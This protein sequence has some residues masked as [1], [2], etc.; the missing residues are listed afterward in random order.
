MRRKNFL[1]TFLVAVIISVPCFSYAGE[2]SPESESDFEKTEYA[3]SDINSLLDDAVYVEGLEEGEDYAENQ[4]FCEASDIDEALRIAEDYGAELVSFEEGIAVLST[5]RDVADI[6]LE[7]AES[8]STNRRIHPDYLLTE[9]S[10]DDPFYSSQWFHG[11]IKDSSAWNKTDGSGVRVAVVDTGIETSHYDLVNKIYKAEKCGNAASEIDRYGHG[12]HVAGI[13]AAEKDNSRGGAGVA[14]GAEIYSVCVGNPSGE[15][16]GITISSLLTGVKKAVNEE[17]AVVNV[18]LGL[19]GIPD[20]ETI[21][22][23]QK[24]MDYAYENG[25][26]VVAS[27]GNDS[28][29][30]RHY[31]AGLNHVIA[32]GACTRYGELAYYSNYGDWV[33]L[34][35]PGSTIYSTYLNGSYSYLSGTSMAAPVVTGAAALIYSSD[36]KFRENRNSAT[37]DEVT[38][39]LLAATDGKK[40]IYSDD[41]RAVTGCIDFSKLITADK[42]KSEDSG[43]EVDEPDDPQEDKNK[44]EK[45]ESEEI[46]LETE[47]DNEIAVVKLQNGGELT[48][49]SRIDYGGKKI[50]VSDLGLTV[51]YNGSVY[52]LKSAKISDGKH[53]GT[54]T[55]TIRKLANA[56]KK[57]NAVF[58]GM[59]LSVEIKPKTVSSSNVSCTMKAD[60][61]IKKVSVNL[62][63][64][65]RRVKKSMYSYDAGSRKINFSGDYQ[66]S[67]EIAN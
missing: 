43:E 37:V 23:M 55:I 52:S 44:D 2:I 60:G 28:S 40:Y 21:R 4:A 62:N 59:T 17:A 31:P 16:E 22:Y 5:G 27:A 29:S 6:L 20:E 32:V 38:E 24:V 54:S 1:A 61:S 15:N 42:G 18:S 47:S 3:D 50:K 51:S 8:Q 35:A 56:D 9:E 14:P 33:D 48:Y 58:K 19:K 13:I 39:I 7:E 11:Y 63:G 26:T 53:A 66:G 30:A 46:P 49:T 34:V 65:N 67:V 41:D 57:I 10:I 25:T 12:T 45:S 64:K 36:E